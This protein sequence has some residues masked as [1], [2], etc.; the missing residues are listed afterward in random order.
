MSAGS[1]SGQV[2]AVFF[3]ATGTLFR[4]RGGVGAIYSAVAG[5]H[6]VDVAPQ[7]LETRFHDRFARA[8]RPVYGADPARWSE[9]ERRWWRDVVADVFS[10][11]R[12]LDFDAFFDEVYR[13]FAGADGWELYP[14][15]LPALQALRRCGRILA[16]ISNFDERIFGVCRALGLELYFD[17][18]QISSR[19]GAAKPD[20]RLFAAALMAHGL[21]PNEA[22]HVGDQPEEDFEG[23]RACG[24]RPILLWRRHDAPPGHTPVIRTLDE[25]HATIEHLSSDPQ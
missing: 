4:V 6:G 25:L 12:F 22:V 14:D 3:D 17:S 11:H 21:K 24:I 16:I 13:R 9:I 8:G 15:A 10:D 23:A 20:R 18:I 19:V 7:L 5:R 2:R 1:A